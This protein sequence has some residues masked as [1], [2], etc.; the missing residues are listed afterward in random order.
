MHSILG[1][2]C[3]EEKCIKQ[4]RRMKVESTIRE[5]CKVI[6]D[7]EKETEKLRQLKWQTA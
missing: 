1:L 5:K 7:Q 2:Q 3:Y 6:I 4:L